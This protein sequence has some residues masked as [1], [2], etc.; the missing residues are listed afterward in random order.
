MNAAEGKRLRF[1]CRPNDLCFFSG[2]RTPA[3]QKL[4]VE[5]QLSRCV[6]SL[7]RKRCQRLAFVMGVDHPF[8]V[9]RAEDV[10]VVQEKR[11]VP[12]G[13]K[14]VGD[15]LEAASS[16][17]QIW[18]ARDPYPQAETIALNVLG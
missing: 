11:L 3:K 1:V 15:F 9:D 16:I 13:Q 8:E 17:D 6:A 14:K 7:H 10:D 18:L 5:Q 12:L 2:D 4:V